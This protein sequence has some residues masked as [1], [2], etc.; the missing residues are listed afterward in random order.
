M[1][2]GRPAHLNNW[3]EWRLRLSPERSRRRR[4]SLARQPTTAAEMAEKW[5]LTMMMM[6]VSLAHWS[7][8]MDSMADGG[9]V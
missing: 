9:A 8:E 2:A 3:P 1:M 4:S 6:M 5:R 7:R